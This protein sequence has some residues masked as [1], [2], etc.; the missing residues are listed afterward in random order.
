MADPGEQF[1]VDFAE[2]GDFYFVLAHA[3]GR[4]Q[5]EAVSGRDVLQIEAGFDSRVG[6]GTYRGELFLA[7]KVEVGLIRR[8]LEG[9]KGLNGGHNLVV[10]GAE[11]RLGAGVEL[12]DKWVGGG[13]G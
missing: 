6:G 2:G 11:R 3:A 4:E 7:A 12:V 8:G 9:V 13:G 1:L 5:E 10:D